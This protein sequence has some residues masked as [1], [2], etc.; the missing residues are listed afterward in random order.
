MTVPVHI[1]F[2][3][4]TGTAECFAQELVDEAPQHG[5]DAHLVDLGGF[6]PQ[7]FQACRIAVIVT[8]TYGDGEPPSNAA[9]FHKWASHPENNGKLAGQRFCVMGLGDM[10]YSRFN[11]MG[12]LTDEN[13]DR[14]GSKRIYK[15][16]V[17]DDS[18]DIAADFKNWKEGGFWAAL[19]KAIK[20]AMAEAPAEAA[21]GVTN[22]AAQQE[23]TMELPVEYHVF[24]A[25][26]ENN[27]AARDV[28]E[29]LT[30]Q[31]TGKGYTVQHVQSLQDRKAVDFVKKM[32]KR[33]LVVVVA[34]S[35]PDGLCD[36][37]Q[38][39]VRKMALDLD[40]HSHADKEQKFALLAVAASK[41]AGTSA[42]SMKQGVESAIQPIC[43][44]FL[45]VGITKADEAVPAYIDAD[46]EIVPDVVELFIDGLGRAAK[47]MR[48]Q[49]KAAV[50]GVKAAPTSPPAL[51]FTTGEESKEA[52]EALGSSFENRDAA[53]IK[54][55]S[56]QVLAGAAKLK[57]DVIIA[58][59]CAADGSL[60]D[61]SRGLVAQLRGT[62]MALKMQFRQLKYAMVAIAA[63]DYG[64]AGERASAS[65][66]K[67]EITR[68]ADAI[69]Q[70]LAAVGATCVV[71]EALDLQDATPESLK[72][73]A[74]TLAAGFSGKPAPA[75]EG[76]PAMLAP[77]SAGQFGTP[78]VKT[79]MTVAGL[80]SEIP[81]E[82][83]DVLAR[84][85]F[86][87]TRTKI[88][89]C[90]ELR[91]Q[92]DN[93]QGLSTVEVEIEAVES[94][95]SYS[96]GGT[97]SLLPLNDPA[98]VKAILPIL[99]LRE[100]D[101]DKGMTFG[102]NGGAKVKKP[103]PTPCTI[104]DALTN[105]CDLGKAPTKKMLQSL[106]DTIKDEVAKERLS[107]LLGDTEALDLLKAASLCLRMHEFFHLVGVSSLDL[108]DFLIHCPRQKH[109]EFTIA[110]SPKASPKRITLCCSLTSHEL[111]DLKPLIDKF[112]AI[113][114]LPP[115][116][117]IPAELVE[118]G[119]FFGT[120]SRWLT[121]SLKA[122]DVVLARQK[123]SPF[124]LPE[125]DVPVIMIGSGAGVAPFRGFWEE[126]KRQQRN[127]PA[128]LFF[129]CRHPDKDWLFKEEMNGAVKLRMAGCAALQRVQAGPKRPLQALFTAFSRPEGDKKGEYVQD[130]VR[131]QA[132][133]VKHWIENMAG[134]VF[135]CGSSAMGHG[136][137][138][139]LADMLEGGREKVDQFRKD[140]RI[141]AEM[142]G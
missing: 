77:A 50:N 66:A 104:R 79:A 37:G 139:A 135:I 71:K 115:D 112:Q 137:L 39:L 74:A 36:A 60:A 13:L 34:D 19:K 23:L 92:P 63:T 67:A 33:S 142:W 105:F 122:G 3:S 120:A 14:L 8:S 134:F 47:G 99:G 31:M 93:A 54:D 141:V 6:T 51:I 102:V 59:E 70:A 10:N 110:S 75:S 52:A 21:N 62:P 103:F 32:P 40:P 118:R 7:A 76:A 27:G 55:A 49:P 83:S 88:A 5:I 24:Y 46:L 119:R 78:C 15:R 124:H 42:A 41:K 107:K 9:K 28:C 130:Q 65:G 18:Q 11:N 90:K 86:E 114:A 84:F 116:H 20:E 44:A 127:A 95:A 100:A 12:M 111:P 80:P 128:A 72:T 68:A 108:C 126:L 132:Q 1:F 48:P 29:E 138:D 58:V 56:L 16:G 96:L 82:A 26:D 61:G 97:F 129:G 53:T 35:G 17:G 22:G 121:S 2:G 87:A 64:N 136:V 30:E 85:Y 125:K 98:H 140:G 89:K 69:V 123:P 101:L 38:K 131:A 117:V 25:H 57:G 91:Q 43:G 109:R 106:R 81:G 45:R 94:L 113:G 4:E 133:S 73:L